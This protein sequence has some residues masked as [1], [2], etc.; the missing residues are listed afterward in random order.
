MSCTHRFQE[1]LCKEFQSRLAIRTIARARIISLMILVAFSAVTI[2]TAKMGIEIYRYR[3]IRVHRLQMADV[4]KRFLLQAEE[5]SARPSPNPML[6]Q[7][8]ADQ[9]RYRK[10]LEQKYRK[11][12]AESLGRLAARSTRIHRLSMDKCKRSTRL[13]CNRPR[14]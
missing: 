10:D 12:A 14:L 4:H 3:P 9:I 13:R 11:G 5:K 1:G 8:V 2:W 6:N 7:W